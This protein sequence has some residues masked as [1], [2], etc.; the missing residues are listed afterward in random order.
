MFL[1]M[2]YAGPC[3][4]HRLICSPMHFLTCSPC[5]AG[6][7]GHGDF[8][9]SQLA[10]TSGYPGGHFDTGGIFKVDFKV[11]DLIDLD[12]LLHRPP[13]LPSPF[14]GCSVFRRCANQQVG[15]CDTSA[16]QHLYCLPKWF[17]SFLL[18]CTKGSKTN[19]QIRGSL[20]LK[21]HTWQTVDSILGV[22]Q[23]GP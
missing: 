22:V 1:R 8:P 13:L 4:S 5:Q 12:H 2:N 20:I 23:A 18:I 19:M 16:K 6:S 9:Q 11:G 7:G 14:S 3:S 21:A 15:A 17:V 10:Q